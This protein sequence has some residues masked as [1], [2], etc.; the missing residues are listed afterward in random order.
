MYPEHCV[1]VVTLVEQL[2]NWY[3]FTKATRPD[4][5]VAFVGLIQMMV[6]NFP[7]CVKGA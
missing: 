2:V 1:E 7:E 6:E 3:Q 5:A 4:L